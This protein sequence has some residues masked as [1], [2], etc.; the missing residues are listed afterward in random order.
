[1]PCIDNLLDA[2]LEL[3]QGRSP[4]PLAGHNQRREE[5]DCEHER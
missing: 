4:R 5:Y 2:Q 3:K 1:M